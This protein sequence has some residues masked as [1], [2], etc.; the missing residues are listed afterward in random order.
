[1]RKRRA[2]KKTKKEPRF[3]ITTNKK[4]ENAIEHP[5]VCG[6]DEPVRLT[7]QERVHECEC[8]IVYKYV[9]NVDTRRV[10]GGD[11]NNT[12]WLENNRLRTSDIR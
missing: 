4:G 10:V 11:E 6:S 3:E 8:G 5:C 1:M 9:P 7:L 2:K 12:D